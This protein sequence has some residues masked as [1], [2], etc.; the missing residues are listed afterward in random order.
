MEKIDFLFLSNGY[1]EDAIAA[2]IAEFVSPFRRVGAFPLVGLGNGYEKRKIPIIA[3]FPPLEG[4]GIS[5]F[6]DIK[7][8]L[9]SLLKKEWTFLRKIQ[10]DI[11]YA[12][13]VGDILPA[14]LA[15]FAL[16]KKFIFVGTAKSVYVQ[17]YNIFER[18]ILK[19]AQKIFVRDEATAYFLTQKSVPANW[20]GNPM[21]DE[22]FE[23]KISIPPFNGLTITLL[24]GSRKD[25]PQ[26]FLLQVEA[27]NF[28]QGMAQKKI[29]GLVVLPPTQEA[30]LFFGK[31][32]GW[33]GIHF[34][35]KKEQDGIIAQYE[36]GDV[37]LWFV[38]GALGEALQAS[39]I[40]F[41]QA[42]TAN[43][44]AAGLGKPV[45]AFELSLSFE[46]KFPKR[47]EGLSWYRWRQKKLLGNALT[48]VKAD[49]KRMAEKAFEILKN[50]PLYEK[51]S[52]EGKKRMG[53]SGACQKIA[54]FLRKY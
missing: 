2:K 18:H 4:G 15:H 37:S 41:G 44:Q 31:L 23:S 12:V 14:F 50:R 3:S 47:F 35:L 40:V 20:V 8:G 29:R 13:A 27:L 19:K 30:R 34:Y 7:S 11:H 6:S 25:A 32:Y 24:P 52:Q 28:L 22:L 5:L 10:K 33:D 36:Q 51:M 38:V 1:G 9:F 21:M 48:I 42:G 54:E 26:N 17:P 49:A 39:S 43:E 16:K 46:F 45:I 53:P